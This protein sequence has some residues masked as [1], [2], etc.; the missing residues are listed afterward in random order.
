[1]ASQT[2][3]VHFKE[4]L[5]AYDFEAGNN[6][7]AVGLDSSG[8]YA[9]VT[10]GNYIQNATNITDAIEAI[11]AAIKAVEVSTYTKSYINAEFTRIKNEAPGN[12][13]TLKEI[14]ASIGNDANFSSNMVASIAARTTAAK[15]AESTIRTGISGEIIRAEDEEQDIQDLLDD[16]IARAK[17]EEQD[18]SG[19]IASQYTTS[20]GKDDEIAA[21]FVAM[22]SA[23]VTALDNLETQQENTITSRDNDANTALNNENIRATGVEGT[24]SSAITAENTRAEGA[25]SVLTTAVANEKIRA[26]GAEGVLTTAVANEKSRA[27]LAESALDSRTLDIE[28]NY[29]KHNGDV[30]MTGNLK[31]GSSYKIVNVAAPSLGTDLSNKNYVDLGIG[32]LGNAFE[33]KAEITVVAGTPYTMSS[34]VGVESGDA[35]K[36]V[37]APGQIITPSGNLNVKVGDI[38]VYNGSSWDIFNNSDILVQPTLNRIVISGNDFG[39]YSV[40]IASTYV[41]QTSITTV[42]TIAVGT[43]EGDVISTTYGG[44]G[45]STYNSGDLLVGDISGSLA[46]LPLGTAGSMLK[47]S[48]GTAAW[49]PEDTANFTLTSALVNDSSVSNELSLTTS[50]TVQEAIDGLFSAMQKRKYVQFVGPVNSASYETAQSSLLN[51]KVHFMNR[52]G[53]GFVMLP[54]TSDE[55]AV[56]RIV[57]N[58]DPSVPELVSEADDND[59]LVKYMDGTTE[60]ELAYI[61][62]KDTMVFVYNSSQS[63]K[64]MSAIGI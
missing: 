12:L 60:V 32:Y 56:I 25:E 19:G 50:S 27:E 52:T 30:T 63:P 5:A 43:Y 26:E 64:W 1:M 21:A 41:G 39:E 20:Y 42:G 45:Q 34:L 44:L 38:V 48:S 61:A 15:A 7:S 14:A 22:H 23:R 16:E 59:M 13:D 37:G 33:Y 47:Y 58:G 55:N 40:D 29:L 17:D 62:P 54:A 8:N 49:V 31:M 36:I 9:V 57:H 10:G 53:N 35:Y 11:D 51:G 46:V 18:I 28:T 6:F 3:I 2:A 24:I 4:E